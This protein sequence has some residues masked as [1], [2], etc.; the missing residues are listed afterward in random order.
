MKALV[1]DNQLRLDHQYPMP[2]P[3]QG[4]ALLK[5]RKA[6]IC[7]TDKEILRGYMGFRGIPGHEFVA[8]VVGGDPDWIGKRVVGEINVACGQCDMCYHE[9]P[10]QCRNRTT[11]GIDRHN[12]AFAEYMALST[13]NLYEVPDH[14]SDHAAVFVEPLAAAFQILEAVSISPRDEIVVI[15]AGKLGMLAAQVLKLTGAHVRVITR[16]QRQADLVAIWGL[17]PITKNDLSPNMA[18]VIVDCTGTSSGF[19]DALDLV[20]PR[21]TIVLKSTYASMPQANL[22]R[23]VV[24]EIKVVGSRCGSF[25]AALRALSLGLIDVESL[26]DAEYAL[27]QALDAFEHASKTGTLKVLLNF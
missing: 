5:I 22:T 12:G 24:D 8:D 7:N 13:A 18:D 9:I 19:S 11:V 23:V 14:I 15:G 16:R 10:S 25:A 2:T 6:G 20:R 21:G 4:Q 3:Q 1:Y 17:E 27:P 26:I